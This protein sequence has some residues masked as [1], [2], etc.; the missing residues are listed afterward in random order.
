MVHSEI[1]SFAAEVD[2][3]RMERDGLIVCDGPEVAFDCIDGEY[4]WVQASRQGRI[5]DPGVEGV[6]VEL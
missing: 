5:D 6:D 1:P 3:G 2:G 4:L